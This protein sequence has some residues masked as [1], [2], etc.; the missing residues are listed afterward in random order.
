MHGEFMHPMR[1]SRV[2]RGMTPIAAM[3]MSGVP[4]FLCYVSGR[5]WLLVH[6]KI[7]HGK[8]LAG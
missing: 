5:S 8:A 6:G 1:A 3:R 7:T 4:K 2:A